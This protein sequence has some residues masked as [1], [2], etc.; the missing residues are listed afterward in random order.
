MMDGS[1]NIVLAIGFALWVLVPF[2]TKYYDW[3]DAQR[4]ELRKQCL[5]EHNETYCECMDNMVF[6]AYPYDEYQKIDKQNDT[7]YLEF[8]KDSKEECFSDSWF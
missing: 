3:E 6:K 8:I 1:F 7:N 4:V 2:Y 5:S